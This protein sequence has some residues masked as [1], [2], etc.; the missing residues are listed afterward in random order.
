MSTR[1]GIYYWKC[2][3][4]AAFHGTDGATASGESSLVE[5]LERALRD[6][7]GDGGIRVAP[8]GGQGN[9]RTYITEIAST[10][11]FLRVEDGPEHDDYFDVEAVILAAI[12]SRQVPAPRHLGSDTSRKTTSFAWQALERIEA[13][14]LN[15]HLKAGT[16]PL[17]ETAEK[18]GTLVARWQA[19]TPAGFGPLDAGTA[20]STGALQGL[21]ADYPAYFHL[22]LER[23]LAFLTDREFLN[24]AEAR[25]IRA[26]VETHGELLNLEAGCL[27]HKDLALW[28]ILGTPTEILA[29]IDWDDAISGDPL[30]DLSLLAC[31]HGGKVIRRALEGYSAVK[32]LPP[33]HRRR[34]WLH[35]L[36]NMLVKA[37]IRLGA[38]Y[39]DRK[40]DFFLIGPGAN[41]QDLRSFTLQRIREAL[42]GLRNDIDP[43]HL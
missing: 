32:P 1:T 4:P 10:P 11:A 41:G 23:H 6:R 29:V 27:V 12:P 20:R 39:F 13:P 34:F 43:G 17:E 21:H 37:V 38:G 31:F 3:R 28:N 36:R 19:I 35:L 22:N 25:E 33:E 30:D 14:D 8:A 5:Q 24:P 42:N 15:Q 16:L 9:H 18:I 26:E 2:D 40:A 7:F